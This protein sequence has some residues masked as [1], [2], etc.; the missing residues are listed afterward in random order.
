MKKKYTKPLLS[1]INI[2]S[3]ISL[4]LTTIVDDS[5]LVKE[6]GLGS[7]GM[8]GESNDSG[9]SN[10]E[11]TGFGSSESKDPFGTDIWK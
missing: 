3:E 7:A 10:W 2:D 8:S 1:V 4:R 6:P 11:R 9:E 5:R